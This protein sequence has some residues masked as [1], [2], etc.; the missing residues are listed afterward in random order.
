MKQLN[1]LQRKSRKKSEASQV[2]C[3]TNYEASLKAFFATALVAS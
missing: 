1:Q 3:S 2:R